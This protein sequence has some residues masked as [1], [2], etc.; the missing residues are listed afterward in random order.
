M[1]G[2]FGLLQSLA[3]GMKLMFKEDFTPTAA[4]KIV[5]YTRAVRRRHSRPSPR[6]PSSRIGRAGERCRSPISSR[7]CR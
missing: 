2:P 4:D 6:S 1:N 5:F 3:D 7:R